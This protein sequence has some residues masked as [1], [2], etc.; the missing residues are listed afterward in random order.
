RR[1]G[2]GPVRN[3]AFSRDG[4]RLIS[5]RVFDLFGNEQE[6]FLW[7]QSDVCYIACDPDGK[8]VV[9][10]LS[11]GRISIADL[12]TGEEIRSIQPSKSSDPVVALSPSGTILALADSRDQDRSR[13][14]VHTIRLVDT[15]TGHEEI[16]VFGDLG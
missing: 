16:G 1:L 3:I 12:T 11:D 13:N 7:N 8:T 10:R 15:A 14:L 9:G 5:G 2:A 4:K 6:N